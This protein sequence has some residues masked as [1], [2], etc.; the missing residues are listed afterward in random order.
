MDVKSA[1]QAAMDYVQDLYSDNNLRDLLL[2]EIEFS[3][4]SDEWLVTVGFSLSESKDDSA[5][6]ITPSRKS[7]AL[8][9][10]YKI[11]NV[12]A[13]TGQPISMKIRPV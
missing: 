9:R 4:G 8:S 10:R 11:I 1:V 13:K 7:R 2:E 12:D 3:E 5:A 6:L